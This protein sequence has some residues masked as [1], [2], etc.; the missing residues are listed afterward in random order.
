MSFSLH[1]YAAGGLGAVSLVAGLLWFRSPTR[2]RLRIACEALLIAIAAA[3]MLQFS[4]H[5]T[6]YGPE[7]A[8]DGQRNLKI[9]DFAH[10]F[11]GSK[12]FPEMGYRGIYYSTAL[13]LKELAGENR[14]VLRYGLSQIKD[15]DDKRKIVQGDAIFA[16]AAPYRERFTAARWELFKNDVEYLVRSDPRLDWQFILID[17]GYNPSPVYTWYGRMVSRFLPLPSFLFLFTSLDVLLLLAAFLLLGRYAGAVPALVAFCGFLYFPAGAY[18]TWTWIGGSF[19]RFTWLFWLALA[20]LFLSRNMRL[21]AGLCFGLATLERVFPLFFFLAALWHLGGAWFAERRSGAG[22]EGVREGRGHAAPAVGGMARLS[23]GFVLSCVVAL[24]AT[25]SLYGWESWSTFARYIASHSEVFALN[26]VGLKKA[27]VYTPEIVGSVSSYDLP[28][29]LETWLDV[30]RLRWDRWLF[31]KV[32]LV[33]LLAAGAFAGLRLNGVLCS[34]FL[35]SCLLYSLTLAAHYYYCFLPLAFAFLLKPAGGS[36]GRADAGPRHAGVVAGVLA[37]YLLTAN[38]LFQFGSQEI[39][40]V[41]GVSLL[42][43]AFLLAA[44]LGILLPPGRAVA[45]FC[46][47]AALVAIV[48]YNR[49]RP[50]GNASPPP[51][52]TGAAAAV[53]FVN[54][55]DPGARTSRLSD[56]YGYPVVDTGAPLRADRSLSATVAVTEA[57]DRTLMIRSRT[58]SPGSL[59]VVVN[60]TWQDQK[61]KAVLGT[62]FDYTEFRIPAAILRPGG[63]LIRL[64]WSGMNEIGIYSA[65]LR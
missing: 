51:A 10:Y 27:G 48:G 54:P 16:G 53:G 5:G 6:I 24:A 59:V 25:G 50:L 61:Q 20:W 49:Q 37:L 38:V 34:I 22:P 23:L 19:L 58:S 43:L 65:W 41:F 52:V 30:M 47:V 18:A 14:V 31:N 64:Y 7:R 28:A 39:Q 36:P 13:A 1:P 21:A 12:Y 17:H 3:G 42:F 46:A 56:T 4:L 26:A 45:S 63:N 9:H 8:G 32:F 57:G 2:R 62:F 40:I 15:L 29:R 60:D 11:L 33:P 55:Q 44:S 35:G